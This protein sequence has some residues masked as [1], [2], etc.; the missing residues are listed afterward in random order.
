MDVHDVVAGMREAVAFVRSGEGPAIL[1]AHTY[2]FRGHSMA[3][4]ELYRDKQ[5]VEVMKARDPLSRVVETLRGIDSKRVDEITAEVETEMEAAVEFA[6]TSPFPDIASL[7][8]GIVARADGL[9]R[10]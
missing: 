4:P 1:E 3:D 6:E 2:R 10:S 5:E 9:T 8:D 7:E